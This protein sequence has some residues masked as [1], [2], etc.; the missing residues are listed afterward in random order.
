MSTAVFRIRDLREDRDIS[1]STIAGYLM[2]DQSL[3]SKY[4]RGEREIPLRLMIRLAEYYHVSVD[5]LVRLTDNP[6]PYR[7][8]AVGVRRL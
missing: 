8:T 7:R 3:Y 4:E 2:C 5:Y 1:Q 6:T